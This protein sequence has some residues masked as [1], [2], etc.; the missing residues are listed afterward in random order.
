MANSH[1]VFLVGLVL[2]GLLLFYIFS[3]RDRSKR[4]IG[5]VFILGV[6]AVT[7]FALFPVEKK[8]KGGID[9]VGGSAYTVRIDPNIDESTGNPLPIYP[10]AVQSAIETIEKR[11][12]PDGS[13]D[14]LLQKQGKDRIIV[15][16]PGVD[17]TESAKVR[18]TLEQVAKLE[19]RQVHPESGFLASQVKSGSRR[20]PGYEVKE[21]SFENEDGET[22]DLDVLLSK[23]IALTGKYVQQAW[24][25]QGQRGI[26]NIRLNSEGGEKM[27]NLTSKMRHGQDRLASVLDGEVMNVA[28]VQSTLNSNFSI[29]GL[30]DQQEALKLANALENPLSN[31]LKIEEAR[32]VSA[33]LGKATVQQGIYAGIVGLGLT[34]LFILFY[35]RLAG[36]V[37]LIG[38]SL[39]VLILFG[40]MAM[41]GFTFTLPGIAGIILTIGVAV[42]ANVLIYERLR[43]EMAAGKSMKGAIKAAYDKAFSAIFDANITTLIT[44]L[45]LFLV[46]SG[47]VKGFAITLTIG[48]LAS[49]VTALIA[50]RVL[51]W[52]GS[53]LGIVKK[54][55]FSN[56]FPKQN[57]PFM[58]LRKMAFPISAILILC[59]VSV[60]GIR[61]DKSLGIDFVGGSI[62]KFQLGE[63][64]IPVSKAEEA[65]S[66]LSLSKT[67][68]VQ[69]ETSQATGNLLSIRCAEAD[70]QT[71]IDELRNDIPQ[72]QTIEASDDSVSGSLG[73]EFLKN[74]LFALL[75][76]LIAIMLY[77]TV[78]FEFSFA[79]GAFMALFHDLTIVLGAIALYSWM[80]GASE[81]SLIHV[82]AVLTIAG[83]S[84]NDTIVVFDRI[85]EQL[86][87]TKGNIETIMN[88]AINSTLS[89][90][91]LTSLTTFFVVLV[92]FIF[93]GQALKDF[94]LAILIGVVVGTYSSIFVAAPIVYLWGKRKG[95]N[96]RE[97]VVSATL[98]D[99][100]ATVVD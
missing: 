88:M 73:K 3:D 23:R 45:I 11:L 68:I 69:Q 56:L 28:V 34:V 72:L 6:V 8:L 83:Y 22:I 33:R 89:R 74:S 79:I 87:T 32:E 91:V 43:E 75:L 14:L 51:F 5:T 21:Y 1:L 18:E 78:R 19:I 65:L 47:T 20:V 41:F 27:F 63:T 96:L 94:S 29:S 70:I 86:Q 48:I 93:G 99:E 15:E 35:Y 37:A 25:D 92:L 12:N 39:N 82:G 60:L 36:F 95:N 40:I 97:E 71:V 10:E 66:D 16:M 13:K 31:P 90:T 9:I 98:R 4:N 84:I 17:E 24:V 42:D 67:P 54:L 46:A 62:V 30:D 26:V 38:L 64:E 81:L 80:T 76:G 61:G 53:D 57:I 49:L 52:W 7:S 50:T 44:A 77:I 85:R 55:K 2:L 59:A 100:A 58:R